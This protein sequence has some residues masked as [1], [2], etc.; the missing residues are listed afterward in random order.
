VESSA[1]IGKNLAEVMGRIAAAADRAGRPAAEVTLLAVSKR[2]D[3]AR[4][5]A[6]LDA[7]VRALGES[8][9]QEAEAKIPGIPGAPE[10]HFIGPLQSNKA[11]KAARL[12]DVIHSVR[13]ESLVPRLS[14]AAAG[15]HRTVRV[16]A[17]VA[18]SPEPP[19]SQDVADATALCR[20]VRESDGLQLEGLMTMAPYD[21]DPEQARPY[22][23]HLRLLRDAL[24]GAGFPDLGLS[25]GMSGDFEVAIEEGATIVRV[26]TA[27]FGARPS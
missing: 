9:V 14:K 13:R 3:A 12:F 17:Q 4:I 10:W 18:P 27:I 16:Y 1:N 19:S 25:M 21:P 26:G 24:E 11:A 5:E 6:A 15:A 8:R 7:G 23:A 20:Q 2:I 22:F